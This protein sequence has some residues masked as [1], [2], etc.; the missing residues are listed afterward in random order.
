M[1]YPSYGENQNDEEAYPYYN[2]SPFYG[3]VGG[4]M[5]PPVAYP[6]SPEQELHFWKSQAQMLGQQLDQINTRV[7]ELEKAEQKE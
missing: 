2:P 3:G 6:I 7:E 4:P 1:P 5:T